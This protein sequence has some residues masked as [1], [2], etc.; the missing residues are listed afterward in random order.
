M[1]Y[2]LWIRL[3]DAAILDKCVQHLGETYSG[4]KPYK[5]F[6]THITIVPS[7]SSHHPN[8]KQDDIVQTVEKS[9]AQVKEELG[10]SKCNTKIHV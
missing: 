1:S 5:M 4:D 2:T 3:K 8:M 6:P 9:V 10:K 7:I